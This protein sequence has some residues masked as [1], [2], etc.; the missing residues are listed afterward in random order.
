MR[1]VNRSTPPPDGRVEVVIPKERAVFWMDDRGRWHNRH[2]RFEH[3]RIIDHFNRAIRR[4]DKGY[5]VTQVR[6][7]I[8]EKVYFAYADTPLFACRLN[9]A[10]ALSLTLNTGATIPLDPAGLF[11]RDDQLYMQC[12][13][14]IV[15][16]GDRALASVAAYLEEA[17]DGLIIRIDRQRYAIPER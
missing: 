5:F 13:D 8:C 4:D 6:G 7:D 3:R 2:G 1:D 14:D 16:F 17:N 12:G 10:P 9:T 11:V 15:K